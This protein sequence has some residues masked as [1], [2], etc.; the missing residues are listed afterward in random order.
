MHL[1]NNSYSELFDALFSVYIVDWNPTYP[2]T[3]F[4]V[5]NFWYV[6]TVEFYIIKKNEK[7]QYLL[8]WYVYTAKWKEA[9]C[10]IVYIVCYYLS[11]N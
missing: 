3:G 9:K 6:H 1:W 7:D 2:S 5:S 8:I 11:E 10:K 4:W